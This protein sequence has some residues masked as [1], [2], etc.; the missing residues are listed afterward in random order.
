MA[1]FSSSCT[2][3]AANDV[4]GC[5]GGGVWTLATAGSASQ[6]K[7]GGIARKVLIVHD[8]IILGLCPGKV[9]SVT[10]DSLFLQPG[11]AGGL[12][13]RSPL[14]AVA[15]GHHAKIPRRAGGPP[16]QSSICTCRSGWRTP[17]HLAPCRLGRRGACGKPAG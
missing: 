1:T 5:T 10:H 12:G 16:G 7:N 8:C 17:A 6:S 13:G 14:V 15:D 3:T 2:S 11:T 9:I 4:A